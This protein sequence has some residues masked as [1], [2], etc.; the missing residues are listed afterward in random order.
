MHKHGGSS[1]EI[2]TSV[3]KVTLEIKAISN[4]WFL[5]V[6]EASRK[7][8]HTIKWQQPSLRLLIR[9]RIL[10]K[11]ASKFVDSKDYQTMEKKEIV[12]EI[13]IDF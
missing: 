9:S 8:I 11:R 5:D 2:P 4:I 12:F 6:A 10:V 7:R 3:D 13:S 1:P